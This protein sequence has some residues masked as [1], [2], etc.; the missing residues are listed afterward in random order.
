MLKA[1]KI[2]RTGKII[3]P[4]CKKDDFS[5]FRKDNLSKKIER[6]HCKCKSCFQLFIYDTKALNPVALTKQPIE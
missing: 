2:Q 3:C 1:D 4:T 5:I 6:N